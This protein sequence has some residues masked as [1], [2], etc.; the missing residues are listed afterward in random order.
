MIELQYVKMLQEA[1]KNFN[2]EKLPLD[3]LS[4]FIHNSLSFE[5]PTLELE[6]VLK[7][8]NNEEVDLD[9]EK[10]TTIQNY[11]KALL[12]LADLAYRQVVLDENLL[13]D[14]HALLMGENAIG[15]LYRNVD[16]AIKGSIHIPPS[17]IKVY[18][19][20]KKYFVTLD[21]Y[22]DV[23]EMAAFSLAQL[24]KIHPFLDGNGK[25]ARMVL[26]YYL[27]FNKIKPVVIPVEMKQTYF[28]C[29]DEFKVEKNIDGLVSML[30]DLLGK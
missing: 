11:N 21:N 25:L 18:D 8:L 20:M 17:H 5:T 13:K 4:N 16:I 7:V 23:I 2:F 3:Y 28:N 6:S 19:R 27:L 30:K 24:D 26:N 29:I 9:E 15:G 10:V 14:A 22:K 1:S 12:F